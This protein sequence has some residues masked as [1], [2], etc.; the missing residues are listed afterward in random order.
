MR[1]IG[2]QLLSL[3]ETLIKEVCR[4]LHL[5][6]GGHALQECSFFSP[7]SQSVASSLGIDTVATAPIPSVIAMLICDQVIAEQVTNKKSLIG[8]FDNFNSLVFPVPMPRIAI[9]V[10][11][12]DASGVYTFKLRMVNLKNESLVAE[13]GVQARIADATQY[14]ELALNLGNLV[15]PEAGKYEFQL[16]ADDVYLH[17][18]TMQAILAQLPQGGPQWQPQK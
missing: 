7:V 16:Y 14:S 15:V 3:N 6:S 1:G 10:K 13:I 5:D 2:G 11:L 8:I 9:Y 17:R 4:N 12:A 18:V